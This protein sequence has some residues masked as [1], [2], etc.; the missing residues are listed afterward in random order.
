MIQDKIKALLKL[1]GKS[2]AELGA[3]LDIASDSGMRNKLSKGSF[4]A[5]DLIK[6][7]AFLNCTLSFEISDKERIILDE[8][9][10]RQK[11]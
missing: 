3:Y 1:R 9:D 2:V 5:D 4:S 10:I 8:S 6:I 7:A 11:S